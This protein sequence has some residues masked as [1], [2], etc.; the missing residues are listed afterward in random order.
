[1]WAL[2]NYHTLPLGLRV[3]QH[4]RLLSLRVLQHYTLLSLRVFAAPE[5]L[6]KFA[7]VIIL[8]QCFGYGSAKSSITF[9]S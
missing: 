5:T 4:Y 3:L 1:M 8:Y 9:D 7:I 6:I 2:Q